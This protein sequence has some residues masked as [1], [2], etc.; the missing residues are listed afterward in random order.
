LSLAESPEH[1]GRAADACY[2]KNNHA[3]RA[4]VPA[5]VAT[6]TIRRR[7]PGPVLR[8]NTRTKANSPL[9]TATKAEAVPKRRVEIVMLRAVASAVIAGGTSNRLRVDPVMSISFSL[10]LEWGEARAA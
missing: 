5:A 2:E 3:T 1:T 6:A 8:L 10:L 7:L 4:T 9:T